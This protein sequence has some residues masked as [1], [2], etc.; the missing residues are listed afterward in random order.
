GKVSYRRATTLPILHTMAMQETPLGLVAQVCMSENGEFMHLMRSV[1]HHRTPPRART[2]LTEVTLPWDDGEVGVRRL[3]ET[4]IEFPATLARP[5]SRP[6]TVYGLTWRGDE[7][8]PC[9]PVRIDVKTGRACLLRLRSD[10]F[11]GE[12]VLLNKHP[13]RPDDQRSAW[14]LLLVDAQK[15]DQGELRLYDGA[16]LWRGPIAR[17]YLPQ[18]TRF[19]FHTHFIPAA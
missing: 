14:L 5:G 11:A 4:P 8:L 3:S 6:Q 1:A 17:A 10:E 16:N 9:L 13:S 19:G 18:R 12:P 15:R 7:P 2:F